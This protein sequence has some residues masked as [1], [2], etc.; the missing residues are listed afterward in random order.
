MLTVVEEEDG[1][2]VPECCQ[3]QE[4]D[5]SLRF[6]ARWVLV[7]ENAEE[8]AVAMLLRLEHG[9]AP[10][11]PLEAS[12]IRSEFMARRGRAKSSK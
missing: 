5:S 4:A 2:R 8:L 7:R 6:R 3:Q 9:R 1:R 10:L 12:P 11:T